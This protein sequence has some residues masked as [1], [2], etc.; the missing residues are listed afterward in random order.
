ML[1]V[2]LTALMASGYLIMLVTSVI[3]C[4]LPPAQKRPLLRAAST[5]INLRQEPLKED[6]LSPAEID[7]LVDGV[8]KSFE[9]PEVTKD[10]Y[11]SPALA[12]DEMLIGLPVVHLVVRGN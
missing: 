3:P 2:H 10:P 12:P 7:Q 4:S 9:D 6:S 5:L 11:M 1:Q 8:L